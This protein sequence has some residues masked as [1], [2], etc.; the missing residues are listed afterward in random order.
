MAEEGS[1]P[2]ASSRLASHRRAARPVKA[3]RWSMSPTLAA[4]GNRRT[5]SAA[6]QASPSGRSGG[7]AL[8]RLS[9][10]Q[11]TLRRLREELSEREEELNELRIEKE[12]YEASHGRIYSQISS[13][14]SKCQA[15]EQ[16]LARKTAECEGMILRNQELEGELVRLKAA[17][18]EE[19]AKHTLRIKTLDANLL[20]ARA[21]I[22]SLRQSSSSRLGGCR[23]EQSQLLEQIDALKRV[24]EEERKGHKMELGELQR[25][26]EDLNGHL[27]ESRTA[28]NKLSAE[29]ALLLSE[30][31]RLREGHA[32]RKDAKSVAWENEMHLRLA[33][34]ETERSNA[35]TALRKA[36]AIIDQ[37]E[38]TRGAL[39]EKDATIQRLQEQIAKLEGMVKLPSMDDLDSSLAQMHVSPNPLQTAASSQ[40]IVP[41][42]ERSLRLTPPAIVAKAGTRS[43]TPTTS[44]PTE[45]IIEAQK[46]EEKT[47]DLKSKLSVI[48]QLNSRL[49]Q[50]S[51]K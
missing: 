31:N 37:E 26:N 23:E 25:L 30:Q 33:E 7:D 21:E 12:K 14:R 8:G 2:I 32:S 41:P 40:G 4:S 1:T 27:E 13:V 3:V 34:L 22:E 47:T 45:P 10:A 29:K 48:R 51:E 19:S 16:Q 6:H 28:M 46:V 9:L 39:Q 17:F 49:R 50:L 20:S 15:L 42:R 36:M 24:L 38:A 18:V 35:K 44:I 5:S 11:N 43:V